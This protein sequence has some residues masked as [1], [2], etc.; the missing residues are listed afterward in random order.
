[1]YVYIIEWE[2]AFDS[3]DWNSLL[4]ILQ[5]ISVDWKDMRLIKELYTKQKVIVREDEAETEETGIREVCCFATNTIQYLR[6]K[7]NREGRRKRKKSEKDKD[8]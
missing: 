4:D 1:M 3:V 7:V 2:K 8:H 6:W 5:D